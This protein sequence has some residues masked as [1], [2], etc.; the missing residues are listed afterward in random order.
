[1]LFGDDAATV[2]ASVLFH[3]VDK[4][5]LDALWFRVVLALRVESN[6]E[7]DVEMF[8]EERKKMALQRHRFAELATESDMPE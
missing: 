1:L 8:A 7:W 3:L 4:Y 5:V 6:L 2:D